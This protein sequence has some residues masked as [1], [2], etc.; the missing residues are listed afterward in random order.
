MLKM[1]DIATHAGV[2]PTTVSFVLNERH[3][4]V[5]I[6]EKTRLKVLQAA[7]ELG[8]RSNGLAR[9]MRTGNTKMLGVLGGDTAE[10][11]V[12][13]ML[14]GALEAADA[15]GYTLKLLRLHAFGSAQQVIRRISELRLMGMLALHLPDSVLAELHTEAREYKTPLVLMDARCDNAEI[16]QVVSDDEGGIAA[17]VDHMVKLGHSKIAFISGGKSVL[18]DARKAAFQAAMARHGLMVPANYFQEGGFGMRELSAQAARALL[19]LAPTKRPTAIVCSGDLIAMATLQ[20][21]HELQLH[22]PH[23]LSVT[24]FANLTAC[25]YST[26]QLTTIEQPFVEMGRTAV[27]MLLDSISTEGTGSDNSEPKKTGRGI[28][29]LPTRLIERASTAP[30]RR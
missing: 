30:P 26:P 20:V 17:S 8:Y 2:S 1:S 27:N 6:S 5:G 3:E 16:T 23:D 25:G 15:Q 18:V 24:G 4:R 14:K 13:R 11:Q 7:E 10:E 28:K 22:V 12:G 21:A 29:V 19:S 9:A